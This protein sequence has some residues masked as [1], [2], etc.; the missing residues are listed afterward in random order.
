MEAELSRLGFG[1]LGEW[2]KKPLFRRN[3]QSFLD[4]LG[5]SVGKP[6][7]FQW[8]KGIIAAVFLMN[9]A[10]GLLTLYW[11]LTERAVESNP[12][13]AAL[14][15]IDPVLFMV[16]KIGL[17]LMGSALLWR[18]R[19]RATAVLGTFLVFFVYYGILIYHLSAL[20]LPLVKHWMG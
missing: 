8:L 20:G 9:I 7:Q 15:E 2:S 11:V 19:F 18:F 12:L 6:H 14:I 13:M 4:T 17:V 1:S 3:R 16:V 10:D 5:L